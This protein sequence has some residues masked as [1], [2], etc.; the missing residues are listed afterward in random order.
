MKKLTYRLFQTSGSFAPLVLRVLLASVMFPH[1][2]Q[3]LLGWFG[4]AGFAASLAGG[5]LYRSVPGDRPFS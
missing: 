4:G 1:G 3:K 5:H 2:A